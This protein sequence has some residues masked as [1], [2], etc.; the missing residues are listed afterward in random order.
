M[1]NCAESNPTKNILVIVNTKHIIAK[2]TN[3]FLCFDK[4][5]VLNFF[6]LN[7]KNVGEYVNTKNTKK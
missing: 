5:K 3:K 6:M 4:I 2:N 1:I 7:S